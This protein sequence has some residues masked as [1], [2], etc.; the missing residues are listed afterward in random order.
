MSLERYVG[1]E[2]K[3]VPKK[4]Y[5]IEGHVIFFSRYFTY[6]EPGTVLASCIDFFF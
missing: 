4:K 2:I 5:P 6:V 3:E 1:L